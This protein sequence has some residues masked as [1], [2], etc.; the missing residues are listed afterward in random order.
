MAKRIE[1]IVSLDP[2]EAYEASDGEVVGNLYDRL[3]DYDPAQGGALRG[4]LALSWNVEEDGRTFTF[5]LRPGLRFASGNPVTAEDAAFSLQRVVLLDKTPAF[6]LEQFG[7]TREN[8][9]ER[10]RADGPDTLVLETATAVAPSFLYYCLTAVMGSVVDGREVRAHEHDGDLGHDWLAFHSAGSG[11]YRLRVWRPVERY[12]LDANDDYWGGPP[13]NRRV[14]VLN[15]REPTTQRLLLEHG[16]ADY[17]RDLDRDQLEGL[18]GN[19]EIGFDRGVQSTLVYLA[20]NQRN[21]NLRRAEVVEALKYLVDYDGIARGILGGLGVVH[22]SIVPTGL[23]GA[24]ADTPYRFDPERARRELERAGL[25]NGFALGIDVRNATPWIDIAQALQASFSQAGVRLAIT[26]GDGKQTLTKY[27]ARHHDLFLGEWT[28]DYPDPHSNAQA[29]TLN[30]DNADQARAKTLA[31]RNAWQDP[32]LE[33]LV[34][35]AL[36]EPSAPRRA[37]LY[38]ALQRQSR[39]VAPFVVMFQKVEVAARRRDVEGLVIGASPDHTRYA[40]IA[41]R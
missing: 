32:A 34:R 17:A 2:A 8:V 13:R 12:A 31:W 29:F 11:P 9:R 15:V 40:G 38:Q 28:P 14:V 3:L 1:D 37:A 19:A 33:A 26:P 36:M 30:E 7:F 18:A 6:I 22:Q 16:D 25:A 27:R 35:Q 5:K 41:K 10:I 4:A 24:I 39:N 23:M 21:P 20:L